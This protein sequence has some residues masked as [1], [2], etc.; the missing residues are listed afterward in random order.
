MMNLPRW[1][2][3]GLLIAWCLGTEAQQ[4]LLVENNRNFR[5]FKYYPG[6]EIR[7]RSKHEDRIIHG[8]ITGFSDTSIFIGVLD[9]V[10]FSEIEII[11]RERI[12]IYWLQ[13]LLLLGGVG[14]FS[15]DSFN[16]LINNQSPVVLAETAY[17]SAG[18]V[19]ASALL[20]PLRY[21]R[22]KAKKWDFLLI[23]FSLI[24]GTG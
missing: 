15:I 11:Y 16:R 17:I 23:D 6:E 20:I 14:Y 4:F 5:N 7:I 21:K 13:G 22:V 24:G 8:P 1:L 3:S 18:M 19:A 10:C 9:E 2:L 12:P